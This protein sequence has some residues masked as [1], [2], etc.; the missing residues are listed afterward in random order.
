[1]LSRQCSGA[2]SYVVGSGRPKCLWQRLVAHAVTVGSVVV[3][4]LGYASSPDPTWTDGVYDGADY[5][6]AA[7][8]V[9]DGMSAGQTQVPDRVECARLGLVQLAVPG[10]APSWIGR[11][12]TS[13]GPPIEGPRLSLTPITP[14]PALNYFLGRG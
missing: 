5:D 13:R 9:T 6:D 2:S 14:G 10:V 12:Q 11:P 1:M 7:R 3:V 8:L 4:S